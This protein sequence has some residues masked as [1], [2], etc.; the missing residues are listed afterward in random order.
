MPRLNR[1]GHRFDTEAKVS[2]IGES[3]VAHYRIPVFNPRTDQL[4][5]SAGVVNETTDASYSSVRTIGASLSRSHGDWRE[6][7]ALNYQQEK[8]IIAGV[9]GESTLLMPGTSWSRTWGKNFI[10]VFDGLRFD[11]SLRGAS[12]ELVSDTNFVQAQGGLKG[13]TSI[14]HGNRIIAR[15][16][17]GSTWTQEFEQ[18]P[19][20]VRFFAGGS[21][22][23]RGYAYQSLGPVDANG[24]V[25]G[26]KN[27]MVGSIELEH[28]LGGKWGIALFYDAG[29]AIDSFNDRLERGA[30][31]GFR[32][33]SPVGPVRIDLASALSRDGRPWRLHINI[34]PDL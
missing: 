30:G 8:F 3:L 34:G 20:S 7:I 23:V 9:G 5:Y 33:K 24:N 29:N 32:W 4:V 11:I 2:E 12:K 15:G 31:F 21:Q 19:T 25:V 6:T 18:L 14:G 10:N 28:N 16:N 27:L 13:I 22:S 26:G 17:L 1:K